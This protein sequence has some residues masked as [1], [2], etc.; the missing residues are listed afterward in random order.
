MLSRGPKD[1]RNAMAT[2][3]ATVNRQIAASEMTVSK[4]MSQLKFIQ[5]LLKKNF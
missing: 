4:Q 5:K 3:K 2:Q 1:I